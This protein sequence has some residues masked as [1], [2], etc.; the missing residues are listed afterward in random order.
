[1]LWAET[2]QDEARKVPGGPDQEQGRSGASACAAV[3]QQEPNLD[4]E[5]EC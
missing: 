1:M 4:V 2:Q 3:S 5:A